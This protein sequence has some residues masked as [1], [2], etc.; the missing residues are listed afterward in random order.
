M[1]KRFTDSNKWDDPFF[2]SLPN[3]IKLVWLY[4]LDKCDHA[5]IYKI[6]FDMMKYQCN[7]KRSPEQILSFFRDRILRINGEKILIIKFIKFQYQK[8]L[9]SNK[10]AIIGVRNILEQHGLLDKIDEIY[11]DSLTITN[12]Y[13]I[14]KDKDKDKDKEKDKDK[15][16]LD[17]LN[18]KYRVGGLTKKDLKYLLGLYDK[19]KLE[20]AGYNWHHIY[21]EGRASR[22]EKERAF[23]WGKNKTKFIENIDLFV[24]ELA[25]KEKVNNERVSF[26]KEKPVEEKPQP[27]MDVGNSVKAEDEYFAKLREGNK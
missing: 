17:I 14:I 3:D 6:N 11:N 1:A 5:G 25:V 24:D 20:I 26:K 8:G 2:T 21:F 23:Q 10:P 22:N 13:A 19:G 18:S 4:M 9:N 16:I 7:C 15:N 27:I 12:D